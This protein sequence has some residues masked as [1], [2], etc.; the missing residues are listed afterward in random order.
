MLR[1]RDIHCPYCDETITLLI[2]CSGGGEQD[3][4]EDCPVCC[5]PIHIHLRLGE[6]GRLQSLEAL[7]EDD[8]P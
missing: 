3:Y 8:V 5:A 2:D 7:R 1:E 6:D 4:Y